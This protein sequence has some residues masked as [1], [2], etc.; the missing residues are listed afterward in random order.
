MERHFRYKDIEALRADIAALGVHVRLEDDLRDCFA[1]IRIGRR[2]AGNRLAI[3]PMEGCDGTLDGKPDELT[4]RRWRRFGAGGAKLIWGEATAVTEESRANTRQLLINNANR[5]ALAHLL[6]TTRQAHR[7]AVGQT[8][9]LLVGL[10]LTHSGRYSYRRP[11]LAVHDP[12]VD[13]VTWTDKKRGRTVSP[14][15]PLLTDDDLRRVEDSLVAAARLVADI[16]FDFVDIKQCHRYLLSELLSARLRDGEYGGP[17]ENRTRLARNVFARIRD[18]LGDRL[19]LATRLNVYDGIPYRLDPETHSG[20]PLAVPQPYLGGWGTNADNPLELDLAEP[21]RYA[22]DLRAWGVQM[23]N[24]TMGSPYYNPHVGRPF[25]RPPV[26][27]YTTPE[28][29]LIGVARHFDATAAVHRAVPDVVV[30][31]T[32]YSWLQHYLLHA[33]EANLRDGR[34]SM[35]GVGRGSLAYPD[36]ARD[37]LQHGA[38]SRQK[39]CVAVSF[40]TALM[41]AKHNEQGQFPTGCVPRDPVYAEVYK[42]SLRT[43]RSR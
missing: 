1:P 42:E 31:G 34:V 15:D 4:V 29:P 40:C 25:E 7:A 3:H 6:E 14:D 43:A 33:G 28:H 24:V 2:T 13:S 19:I 32:G 10:Q 36:F 17:Y 41:R 5:S 11:L 30:V 12:V 39:T 20:S 27:G 37:A 9:D 38:M 23:I 22:K 21:I 16:G 35:V 26:D 18:E 8:D